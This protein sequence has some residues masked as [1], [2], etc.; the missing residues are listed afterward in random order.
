VAGPSSLYFEHTEYDIRQPA[1]PPAQSVLAS[2][3]PYAPLGA[4]AQQP[5]GESW[6]KVSASGTTML[7]IVVSADPKNLGQ[8]S[9]FGSVKIFTTGVTGRRTRR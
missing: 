8:G 6:L 7:T 9:Y 5:A 1:Y 4:A 2:A 3:G